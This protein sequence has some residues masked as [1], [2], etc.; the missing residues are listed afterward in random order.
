MK[1]WQFTNTHEPLVLNEV[2]EPAAAPGGVV[3]DIKAAGLCHS[4]VGM[5]EDEGWL[6]TLAKRP[7]TLGHEVAGVITEVGEGVTDWKVGD[8]VGFCPTTSVGAPGYGF[9]GG[10]SFK[11][12]IDQEAL[13][14]IPDNV[15]FAQGA[16]GTDAG[17]TSHHAVI[18]NGQV[19]S[20]DKVGIIGFGG[21]GSIGARVAVLAGAEV[22]VAEVNEKVWDQAKEIGATA[23]AKSIA[24]FKEAGLDVIVD[25]AGFGTTTAEAIETVRRGGRVVQVGMGRLEA[26]I[27][28]KALI[29]SEVTLVGSQGGTKEDVQGVYDFFATGQLNP[30]I[31]EIDFDGIPEGIEKLKRG[32]VVGRLVAKI[33]D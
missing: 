22:Y 9:D 26:T 28:T 8:R 30:T 23:V 18:A 13:V 21:L 2:D 19:K 12:A 6:S 14:R 11:A 1:A 16:A 15:S 25:F 10:F 31:T 24:E 3:I 20:G 29:L 7:I 5:L 27:S 4:D 33:A 17:M 32:E